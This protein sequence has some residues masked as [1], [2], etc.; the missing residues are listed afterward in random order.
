MVAVGRDTRSAQEVIVCNP[1]QPWRQLL[2]A[3]SRWGH[4]MHTQSAG[5]FAGPSGSLGSLVGV[6]G[7]GCVAANLIGVGGGHRG[8][9]LAVTA[10]LRD[11][12]LAIV[13]VVDGEHYLQGAGARQ[14][15]WAC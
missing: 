14:S 13:H 8:E 6:A 1:S 11:L 4:I 7:K 12:L 3:L 15:A 9:L 2:G 5:T 10:G